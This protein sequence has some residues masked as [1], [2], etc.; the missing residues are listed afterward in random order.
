MLEIEHAGLPGAWSSYAARSLVPHVAQA[1]IRE[2]AA[3]SVRRAQEGAFVPFQP[4]LPL[5]LK[6]D[7]VNAACA[8]AAELLPQ[9]QRRGGT[10]CAYQAQDA[11][12]LIQ[13]IQAWTIL[14]AS[15][16]V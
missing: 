10:T 2:A 16:L 3:R 15:T 5:D 13:V 6:I 1:S 9:T 11:A 4:P 14:A 8:D 7:F 12:T